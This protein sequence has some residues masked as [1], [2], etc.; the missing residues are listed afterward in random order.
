MVISILQTRE[1]KA[2]TI[3]WIIAGF[4]EWEDEAEE[5]SRMSCPAGN[6]SFNT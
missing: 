6:P 3:M 1:L 5:R 2:E 4:I